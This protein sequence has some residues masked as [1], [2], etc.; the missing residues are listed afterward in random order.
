MK[1]H[2][3][4]KR[5]RCSECRCWFEPVPTAAKSQRV[6]GTECR[7]RRRGRQAKKRRR[8]NV[9]ECRLDEKLR[10]R[11]SRQRR[12]DQSKPGEATA[13]EQKTG[14][15]AVAPPSSKHGSPSG[16][17]QGAR[18]TP[19]HAPASPRNLMKGISKVL[20]NWDKEQAQSRATLRAKIQK[21]LRG[22][23]LYL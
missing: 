17:G 4:S 15:G 9:Q 10:Q 1:K 5:R 6:C 22:S 2:G 3:D 19:C 13:A 12:Q 18:E 23:E 20:E 21:M 11:A 16:V 8:G 14:Q 7:R